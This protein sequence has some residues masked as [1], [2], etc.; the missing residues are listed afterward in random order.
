MEKDNK[1]IYKA[2]FEVVRLIPE[3][4]VTSYGAVAKAVGLKSGARMVGRA[5]FLS[6]GETLSVPVHRV[7]NSSGVIVNDSGHREKALLLEGIQVRND[8]IIDFNKIFW[9]PLKEIEI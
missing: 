2:I 1:E 5:M 3:G 8:K 6:A 7:V 9:D 4:R